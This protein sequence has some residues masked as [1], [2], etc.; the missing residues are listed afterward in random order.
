VRIIFIGDIFGR[1]GRNAV[2]EVLP[3]LVRSRGIDLIIANG[4]NSAAGFGITPSLAEELLE[5]GIEVITTGNHVWDKREIIEFFNMADGNPYSP[6]R[7]VLRP[8]NYPA[9][10]PGWGVYEGQ[11]SQGVPYAIINLQGRVFMVNNEDPFRVADELLSRI[12][13]NVILVDFHAEATSEKVALG[14]HLDGRVTAVLGTHTHI[15]TADERVLPNGTAYQTDVGMTG[16]YD[17]VIGVTKETILQKFRTN[18][19]I[20]FEPATGD[21]R[22][23]AVIIDCDP[24]TGRASSIER[25]MLDESLMHL[26]AQRR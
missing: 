5:T 21:V 25:L 3:G 4:E 16:P 7:R 2:R 6:A 20:R 13:A 1:P 11:T 18:M 9:G 15:P 26:E 23:C 8:A 14:W 17:S 19:P 10:T 22:F 12:Q 24:V